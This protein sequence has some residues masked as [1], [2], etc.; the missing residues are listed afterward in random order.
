MRPLLTLI[1]A[2]FFAGLPAADEIRGIVRA[3][4]GQPI[5]NVRVDIATAA[6]KV[7]P[8]I[9][10]PSCY[11]DCAKYV[12]TDED[13]RFAIPNLDSSLK[14]RLLATAPDKTTAHTELID[15]LS[16]Q[17]EIRL[18]DFPTDLPPDQIL[19]GVVLTDQGT[20][21]A[22]ALVSPYGAKTEERRWWGRVTGAT[23]G[24]TDNAGRFRIVITEPY[25]AIDLQVTAFGYAGAIASLLTPGETQHSITL[26]ELC[27]STSPDR[28]RTR[29]DLS[30]L[31]DRRRPRW[32]TDSEDSH[33]PASQ[34]GSRPIPQRT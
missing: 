4:D 11:L 12:Y 18:A 7:G 32:K 6:P 31:G 16:D 1:L 8:G 27:E 15:P 30:H 19:Q 24:V 3:T 33:Y 5:P 10:C 26:P 25:V 13:G 17:V 20:P 29:S 23:S 21:V 14:F 28:C 22:G 34:H 9:F 2:G